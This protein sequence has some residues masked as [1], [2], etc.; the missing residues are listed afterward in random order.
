MREL[1][2]Q[3]CMRHSTVQSADP[4]GKSYA[5]QVATAS[6]QS[7]IDWQLLKQML[8]DREEDPASQE[9]A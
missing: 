2:Q 6:E 5:G 8:T 9:D 7:A 4:A 1:A 3:L